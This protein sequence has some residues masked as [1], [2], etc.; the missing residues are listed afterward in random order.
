MSTKELES[1]VEKKIRKFAFQNKENLLYWKLTVPGLR[2]VPDRIALF[3]GG[4][5][6]FFELKRPGGRPRALQEYFV[7]RLRSFGFGC[8]VF[9]N[10]DEAIDKIREYL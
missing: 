10:A 6:I 5:V 1:S 9:D 4:K 3:K 7:G 8:F 2:G